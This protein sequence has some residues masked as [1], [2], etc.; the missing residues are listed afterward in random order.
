MSEERSAF[1]I[2]AVLANRYRLDEIIGRGSVATV[3]RA[4][5]SLIQREV[6]L[7]LLHSSFMERKSI[8]ARFLNEARA[9]STLCH[10]NTVIIHDFG[11]HLGRAFIVFEHVR[12]DSLRQILTEQGPLP[13]SRAVH[14]AEQI[15]A[16]L[17]E[18]HDRGVVHR[19][20]RPENV[21]I[22][23]V[24]GDP[25]FVKLVDFGLARLESA[26]RQTM[27]G[28][29]FAAPSYLSP[30]QARGQRCTQKGDLYAV[31]VILYEMLAGRPPFEAPMIMDLLTQHMHATPPPFA[32]QGVFVP[33]ALS[34]Q[35]MALLEKRP[36]D[37][38]E[39]AEE[40]AWALGHL[41]NEIDLVAVEAPPSF[42]AAPRRDVEPKPLLP[43]RRF[44]FQRP[45]T[46]VGGSVDSSL[47]GMT[48]ADQPIDVAAFDSLEIGP[49]DAADVFDEP[50]RVAPISRPPRAAPISRP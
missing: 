5:D 48:S 19:D 14:I 20:L 18:A 23:Q 38:P 3:Y 26:V 21:L 34:D 32:A 6:A 29:I 49:G 24:G 25:D 2:G 12:G 46:R 50:P 7:K 37:R 43:P 11:D 28:E 9:V 1:S 4:F 40:A 41:A 30:E 33:P 39:R 27:P 15:L 36:E 22:T 35:V 13:L 31:G 10:P 44:S 17:G 42:L 45:I 47:V 8:E 16:A